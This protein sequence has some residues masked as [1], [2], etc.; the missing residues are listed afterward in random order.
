MFE[1][2][3]GATP[4]EKR[5]FVAAVLKAGEA[6]E[7][8]AA[9]QHAVGIARYREAI[10]ICP[11]CDLRGDYQVL[12]GGHLFD[13]GEA[14]AAAEAFRAARTGACSYPYEAERRLAF[15]LAAQGHFDDAVTAMH[16]AATLGEDLAFASQ[17]IVT[18][19]L[20][21]GRIEETTKVAEDGPELAES[22]PEYRRRLALARAELRRIA[23]DRAGM[24]QA[25]DE[26]AAFVA[27]DGSTMGFDEALRLATLDQVMGRTQLRP[28]VQ[29]TFDETPENWV[30]LAW[31]ILNGRASI[32]ALIP[33]LEN[34]PWGM[35]AENLSL[36][37]RL[38]GL[39]AEHGGD[40]VLARKQYEKA[41]IEPFTQWCLDYHL[42]GIGLARLEAAP[43]A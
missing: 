3:S 7:L 31:E 18:F 21:L 14:A 24:Q 25:L 11:P 12:L 41:R 19:G 38:A 40:A 6:D 43:P 8:F 22:E 16:Q 2:I 39:L 33:R 32:G 13:V 23:G 36:F 27:S 26:A 4:A 1:E 42:A 34:E 15:A 5:R 9:G 29:A 17:G 35:R 20:A 10:A 30:V 37:H 28:E